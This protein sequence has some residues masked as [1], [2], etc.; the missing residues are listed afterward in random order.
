MGCCEVQLRAWKGSENGSKQRACGA[1]GGTDSKGRQQGHSGKRKGR[2]EIR[3]SANNNWRESKKQREQ[4]GKEKTNMKKANEK[5]T[6]KRAARK[7]IGPRRRGP[8]CT[9]H[10]LVL[11]SGNAE[12]KCQAGWCFGSLPRYR[13]VW[14]NG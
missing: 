4:S 14:P 3:V 6:E 7:K 8:A 11:A 2:K 13:L 10:A 5:G 12:V 9:T 1:L